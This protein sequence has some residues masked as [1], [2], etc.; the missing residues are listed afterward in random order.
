MSFSGPLTDRRGDPAPTDGPRLSGSGL[1][2]QALRGVAWTVVHTVVSIPL[3]FVVNLL[4]A[5]TLGTAH[6]GRLAYLTTLI[7]IAGSILALGLSSAM[8]QFG[9]KA[10]AAGRVQEV[11]RILSASQGFRI[12]VVAPLLT[13]LVLLLVDVRPALLALGIVFGVWLPAALDGAVIGMSIENKSAAAARVAMATN[14][15]VQAG[16]VVAVLTLGTADAVWAARTAC[17]GAAVSFA[18]TVVSR[19]YLRAVLRPTL[20][21]GF[22]TGF[23]RFAIPTGAAALLGELVVSRTEVVFLEA[24]STPSAVGLFALAFGVSSHAFAPAHALT[25]PL[26]PAISGLREVD[27]DLV[28]AAFSRS[29]RASSTLVALI[30]AATTPALAILV[31]ALY[32]EEYSAA[33]PAVLALGIVGSLDVAGAPALAFVLARLSGRRYL[34]VNLA[35]LAVD[36]A[37]A[38]CL[39]PT[40]GLWGAVIANASGTLVRVVLLLTGEQRAL[41]LPHRALLAPLAPLAISVSASAAAWWVSPRSGLPVVVEAVAAAV[42]SLGCVLLGLRLTRT[43]LTSEDA[44]AVLGSLPSRSRPFAAKALGLVA[45]G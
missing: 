25:G 22:P 30:G 43:G 37:V 3:A 17:A 14:V 36:V 23:W 40:L 24:F 34:A 41:R 21:R 26:I 27:K 29:L 1:Q 13:L 7:G 12:L 33:A 20:P 15:V 38:L 2:D 32:G 19:S 39:I 44:E 5:R 6:Y 45:Q 42:V 35:A 31:P 10:H 28:A 16:V 18:L 4:L 11:R 9:A 8:I